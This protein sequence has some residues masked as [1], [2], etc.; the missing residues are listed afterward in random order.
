MTTPKKRTGT[1]PASLA[2]ARARG[3]EG[4]RGPKGPWTEDEQS[5]MLVYYAEGCSLSEIARRL[6][7]PARTVHRHAH[8][9]GLTFDTSKTATANRVRQVDYEARR[10]AAESA[11]LDRIEAMQGARLERMRAGEHVPPAQ[12]VAEAE[13]MEAVV[14]EYLKIARP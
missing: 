13:Q 10:I 11:F 12:M 4:Y 5:K 9:A 14:D 8:K 2:R 3:R 6:D 7:R 1:L